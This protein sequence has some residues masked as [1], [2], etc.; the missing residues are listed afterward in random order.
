[1]CMTDALA[2]WLEAMR[3]GELERAWSVSDRDLATRGALRFDIPRH[4]QAIWNGTPIEGQRVLIRCY[5]GLGDTIQ[6]ARYFRRVREVA[7]EVIVWAQPELL[8]LLRTTNGADQWLPLHDGAPDVDYDVDIESMELPYLFRSTLA[9]IPRAVPYLDAVP[10]PLPPSAHPRIGIAWRAGDWSSSRSISL[11]TLQPLLALDGITFYNLNREQARGMI[12]DEHRLTI[13]GTAS[14]MRALDL[15]ITVDSMPAHLAGAL[16]I[17]TWTL[18]PHECDWRWMRDRD[19]SP[20]YPSMRL[21]RQSAAG[22]WKGVIERVQAA[23][24]AAPECCS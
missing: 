9:T 4:Q 21:F 24:A 2:Q 13:G 20:W 6:F 7:R 18:L 12:H 5:H 10:A 8:D 17:P 16:G 1:M 22:D 3:C 14:L 19:D 15:V 23:I 11:E